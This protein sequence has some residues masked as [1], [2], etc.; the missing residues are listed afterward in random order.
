MPGSQTNRLRAGSCHSSTGRAEARWLSQPGSVPRPGG[1]GG[2][3]RCRTA[4]A[5]P[6]GGCL[7]PARAL[8]PAGWAGCQADKQLAPVLR[9]TLLDPDFSPLA[10]RQVIVSLS[11]AEQLLA[12]ST[13]PGAAGAGRWWLGEV[14]TYPEGREP[15]KTQWSRERDQGDPGWLQNRGAEGSWRCKSGTKLAPGSSAEQIDKLEEQSAFLWARTERG[16]LLVVTQLYC[17]WWG[18]QYCRAEGFTAVL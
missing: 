12:G 14:R 5:Q 1:L 13:A 8:G 10:Q 17:C 11:R 15:G 2:S 18:T 4:H 3:C 16:W 6:Q 7:A 9:R